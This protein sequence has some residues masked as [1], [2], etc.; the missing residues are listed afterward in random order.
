MTSQ[1]LLIGENAIIRSGTIIYSG[2][3]IGVGK[4]NAP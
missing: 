4:E 3:T 1:P 2:T